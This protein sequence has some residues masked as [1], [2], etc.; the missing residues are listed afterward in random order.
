M[1]HY[2]T[3]KF[4]FCDQFCYVTLAC[5]VLRIY[6]Y[7]TFL[8]LAISS[9]YSRS[10]IGKQVSCS[11]NRSATRSKACGGSRVQISPQTFNGEKRGNLL[12]LV[13]QFLLV[14]LLHV[15]PANSMLCDAAVVLCAAG[16][17]LCA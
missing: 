12:S 11:S 3:E 16:L 1:L 17:V 15:V 13:E 2:A 5:A 7:P 4:V 8:V 10:S 6:D 14:A 9:P